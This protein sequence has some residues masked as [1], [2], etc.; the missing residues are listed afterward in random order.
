M[1]GGGGLGVLH[2]HLAR[3]PPSPDPLPVDRQTP[4][5]TLDRTRDTSTPTPRTRPGFHSLRHGLYAP[6]VVSQEDFLITARVRSTTEGYSFTLLV[7][8][9]GGVRSSRGGSGPAAGGGGQ[10]Q[11]LGGSGPAAG[12]G[13]GFQVQLPGGFRSSCWGGSGPAAG[14]VRSSCQRGGQV[15]LPGGGRSSCQGGVSQQGGGSASCTLLRAVCLLH[16]RRRT[17]LLELRLLAQCKL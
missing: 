12:G 4:V 5:K 2:S 17:F 9:Q 1:G 10:V 7:C 11:L 3:V 6:L 14:G 16:S 8:S 13:G 15:Q